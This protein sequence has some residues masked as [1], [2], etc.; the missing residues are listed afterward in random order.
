MQRIDLS[1]K[2]FGRLTALKFTPITYGDGRRRSGWECRCKCG[3]VIVVECENLKAGRTVSCGCYVKDFPQRLKH[4]E[5]SKTRKTKEY[6]VWSGMKNR[7]CCK[8]SRHY[9]Y[10][11]GRGIRVCKRWQ[12]SFKNFLADMGRSPQGTSI[13]RIDNDGDYKPSNCKWGTKKEQAN[14]RRKRKDVKQ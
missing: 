8:T 6:R 9:P 14:N 1:G 5:A 2:T 13:E 4:G 12:K 3:K 7:C 11:G 10:W